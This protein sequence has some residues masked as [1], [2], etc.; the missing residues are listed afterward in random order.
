MLSR[1]LA[2]LSKLIQ[3]GP[4]GVEA[5]LSTTEF[6]LTVVALLVDLLG[7]RLGVKLSASD[8]MTIATILVVAYGAFRS[9]RKRGGSLPTPAQLVAWV[10]PAAP[11]ATPAPPA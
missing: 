5:G 1:A 11:A 4:D 10:V 9:W 7:P 8:Q 6:W 2:I 3:A